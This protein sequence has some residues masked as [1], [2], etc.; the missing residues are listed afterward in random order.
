M[1]CGSPYLV[2]QP[3]QMVGLADRSLDPESLL[4][5]GRG[6]ERLQAITEEIKHPLADER[7]GH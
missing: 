1:L 3:Y 4:R 5:A 2:K 6:V 7:P